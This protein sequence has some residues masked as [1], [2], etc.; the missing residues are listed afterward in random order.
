MT[1]VL[2][3]GQAEAQHRGGKAKVAVAHAAKGGARPGAGRPHPAQAKAKAPHQA[4]GAMAKPVQKKTKQKDS[5]KSKHDEKKKLTA[6]MKGKAKAQAEKLAKKAE[7]KAP[8]K[9]AA[10]GGPDDE[11]I[12]L[13][14]AAHQRLHQADH[15]YAGHRIRAVEHV[16]SA[17]GHLGSSAQV[18][19]RSGTGRGTMPQPVSD[20]HL[21]EARGHLE[22]IK[23]RL[24][25]RGASAK[26]HGEAHRAVDAAIREIDVALAIR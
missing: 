5:A 1:F 20:T 25:V 13:L 2:W 12:A 21:Q 7:K 17:L 8:A 16:G 10:R 22:M 4:K 26:G 19:V 9:V 23:N 14:R 18:G 15:D 11:S 3:I 6:K 24:A